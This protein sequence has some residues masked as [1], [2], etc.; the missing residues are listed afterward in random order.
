[1]Q[2]NLEIEELDSITRDVISWHSNLQAPLFLEIYFSSTEALPQ[3]D[4]SPL[5]ERWKIVYQPR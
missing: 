2:F 4:Y 5:M 3:P 1:M